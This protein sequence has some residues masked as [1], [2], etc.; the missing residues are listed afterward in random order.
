M[1]IRI[2]DLYEHTTARVQQIPVQ[3]STDRA[4][5][6]NSC[7]TPLAK[8][9]GMPEP[10]PVHGSNRRRCGLRR[11]CERTAESCSHFDAIRRVYVDHLNLAATVLSAEQ[12][13]HHVQIVPPRI[14]R[15]DHGPCS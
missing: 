15:F 9:R 6:S 13:V 1:C 7:A 12:P 4:S 5:M 14:I 8:H 3:R 2:A 10:F 11:V